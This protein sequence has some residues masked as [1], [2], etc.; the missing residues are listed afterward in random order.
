MNGRLVLLESVS[1]EEL[2]QQVKRWAHRYGWHGR[3]VRYSQ[4]VVEGVHTTRRDGHSDAHGALDWLFRHDD[5]SAPVLHVELKT[6]RGKL[7][8]EQE[9]EVP[10]LHG[11]RIEAYVWRP[12]DEDEI[13][14][15]L[16][17]AA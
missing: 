6:A 8:S 11:R 2:A 14:R 3:H 13:L 9:V 1:E 12:T 7:T 17:G 10:G 4:G 15:V 16:R 5:P